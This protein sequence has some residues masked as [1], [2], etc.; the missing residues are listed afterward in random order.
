[1]DA[2]YRVAPLR[3][4]DDVRGF[5][6]VNFYDARVKR[7]DWRIFLD[8]EHA[9]KGG[10]RETLVIQD[11]RGYAHAVMSTWPDHDLVHGRVLRA[12]AHACNETPGKLLHD[13]IMEAAESRA[14]AMGCGGVV[15]ELNGESASAGGEFGANLRRAGF[16]PVAAAYYRALPRS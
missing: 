13:T 1:M 12:R 15:L 14:R 11:Q 5:A 10:E 9:I 2:L 7:E 8:A 6:L 3:D 4:D 16:R